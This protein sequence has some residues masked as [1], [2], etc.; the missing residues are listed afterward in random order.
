[1]KFKLLINILMI[2]R[3]NKK[4]RGRHANLSEGSTNKKSKCMADTIL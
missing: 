3:E 4:Q 2:M 1:M